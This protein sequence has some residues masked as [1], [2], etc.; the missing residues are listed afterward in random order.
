MDEEKSGVSLRDILRMI[1]KRIWWI[2]GISVLVALIA[3]LL[4]GLVLNRGKDV[5][6]V[7][8]MLEFPGNT[9]YYPDGT[10]F[11]Y[12]SIVYAENLQRIKDSDEQFSGLDVQ[13]M[14]SEED[15]IAIFE[16]TRAGEENDTVVYTGIYEIRVGSG[17]FKSEE[18]AAVFLHALVE[19]TIDEVNVR[20]SSLDFTAWEANYENSDSYADRVSALRRQYA[21][22][23]DEYDSY[24]ATGA[25]ASF[26]YEGRPL[27]ALRN[28]LSALLS[29]RIGNL[30][31]EL[32][33]KGYIFSETELASTLNKIEALQL[34][35]R[36]NALRIRALESELE[37]LY[38]I[39]GTGM[40]A[41]QLDTFESFHETIR[42]LTDRNAEIS[43]EVGRLYRSA[44][45]TDPND[46]GIWTD[47][48]VWTEGTSL[49]TE[50]FD[51]ELE[52]VKA[53]LMEQTA[54]CKQAIG[55]L[56]KTYS[57]VAFEQ[58][59]IRVISGGV[60]PFLAAAAGLVAAFLL[61][62]LVFC[63]ADYPKYKKRQEA[64]QAAADGQSAP[65]EEAKPE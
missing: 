37:K 42:T 14:S 47:G 35:S 3:G 50:A 52:A 18:Q 32:A 30:E 58:S 46:D 38:D 24:L 11:R 13:K 51:A 9:A 44:G 60:D 20:F 65:E 33:N 10:P 34:E 43:Y 25:Y 64:L 39:Y 28:E 54:T 36:Q 55:G 19:L 5:Y 31:T 61:A 23:L 48:E 62:S 1:G 7:A 17:Y 12:E 45:Y 57:Y 29:T 27:S 6:S 22:L 40:S 49:A 21:Y 53:K 59:G 2:L 56:Y 41:S 4:F 63:M 26:L 15:G 8:F 16:R